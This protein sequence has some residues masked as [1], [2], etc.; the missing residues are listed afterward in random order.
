MINWKREYL[1]EA[2]YWINGDNDYI[3]VHREGELS[4]ITFDR[5]ERLINL[6]KV[7]KINIYELKA[8][9]DEVLN[10]EDL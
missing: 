7:D 6:A 3:R 8:I 1:Y 2:G 9:V 5:K 10:E 4:F